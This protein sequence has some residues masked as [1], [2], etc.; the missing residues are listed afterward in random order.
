MIHFTPQKVDELTAKASPKAHEQAAVLVAAVT[1][2]ILGVIDNALRAKTLGKMFGWAALGG[3]NYLRDMPQE[4]IETFGT[5][6]DVAYALC[7]KVL[8]VH[9][10]LFKPF[11]EHVDAIRR[12]WQAKVKQGVLKEGA[13]VSPVGIA[14]SFATLTPRN[15]I[16]PLDEPPVN[17]GLKHQDIADRVN[18]R[19]TMVEQLAGVTFDNLDMAERFRH[20][21]RPALTGVKKMDEV[22]RQLALVPDRGGLGMGQEEVQEI[23][24]LLERLHAKEVEQAARAQMKKPESPKSF[25]PM[26]EDHDKELPMVVAQDNKQNDTSQKLDELIQQSA[27]NDSVD[28][29]ALATGGADLGASRKMHDVIARP[30]TMGPLEELRTLDVT[31]FRRLSTKAGAAVDKIKQKLELLRDDGVDRYAAGIKAWRGSPLYFLYVD[32]VQEGLVEGRA[33]EDIAAS[34]TNDPER[35]SGEELQSIVELN[36]S[37]RF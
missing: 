15:D 29:S 36:K 28:L 34:D 6:E 35:L 26:V 3:A 10:D 24:G 23:V 9:E 33:L 19:L 13:L 5:P 31:D 22:A 7:D 25:L 37:L 18:V 30:L 16:Q 2:T 12:P 11:V 27:A 8:E 17:G 32:M 1:G 4:I 21:I 14:S 20:M